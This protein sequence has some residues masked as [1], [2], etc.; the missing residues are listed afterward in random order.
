MDCPCL[1][2]KTRGEIIKAVAVNFS[3]EVQL[4]ADEN[5]V[6]RIKFGINR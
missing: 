6:A 1:T 3:Q 5:L 2:E 4:S